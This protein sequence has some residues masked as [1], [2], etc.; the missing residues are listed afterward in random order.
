MAIGIVAEFNPFHN[1]HKYL[2]SEAKRRT[3]DGTAVAVMSGAW[4]QRGEPAITD[5][6]T[7]A[8]VALENGID[9][10]LE[11]PAVYSLNT[12]QRFARG[13]IATL[14]ATGAVT[15]LAFGSECGDTNTLICAADALLNEPPQVSDT[16]KKLTKSGMSFAAAREKAFGGL[17]PDGLL[18]APNDILGIEYIRA[19]KEL[20]ERFE[21]LAISRLGAAHDGAAS[22]G[23]ASAS[24]LRRMMT[25]GGDV[26]QYLPRSDFPVYDAAALDAAVI[27]KL[28]TCGTEYLKTVNDVSEG[29][30][31]RFISATV[32]CSTV[33]ELCML[34]KSKRYALSRIRRIA[35]SAL[36]GLTKELAQRT[37]SY[38]RVLGM[39][40]RGAALLKQIKASRKKQET[41]KKSTAVLPVIIKPADHSGDEIFS[42][43]SRAE[44]VFS[45]CAPDAAL[46]RGG[47]DLTTSPVIL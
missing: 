29:L 3:A 23:I 46:R 9:L 39:N 42:F 6:H 45:L 31:N 21:I 24:E 13:A 4:V 17:I 22:D 32:G 38:I 12:A 44:D 33:N 2:I 40:S 20:G 41:E 18:S 15:A 8:R 7:R 30:E 11:L 10:V 14:A 28:R 16:I 47:R 37:P 25:N 1:G 36:L 19:M 35:Y 26:S 43:N 34:V 27:S 5:K